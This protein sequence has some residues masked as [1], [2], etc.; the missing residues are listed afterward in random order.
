MIQSLSK[1]DL[2]QQFNR[3]PV[4]IVPRFTSNKEWHHHVFDRV[5]LFQKI[6]I[7]K[8]KTTLFVAVIRELRLT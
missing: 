4:T 5:K 6:V 2:V 3:N 8:D 1:A 7:L